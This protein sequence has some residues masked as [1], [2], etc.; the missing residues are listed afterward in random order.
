MNEQQLQALLNDVKNLRAVP[1]TEPEPVSLKANAKISSSDLRCDAPCA[2]RDVGDVRRGD[3][4]AQRTGEPPI[5]PCGAGWRLGQARRR[6]N[7]PPP[8]AKRGALAREIRQTFFGVVKR[9]LNLNDEQAVKLEQ[10]DTRFQRERNLV[11][12][13]ERQARQSLKV[14]L[15]DTTGTPDNA[16]I[17]QYM[18][19]LVQA[20]HKRA[21]LLEAEQKELAGFLTPV[22]RAQYFALRENL[23]RR[24][25]QMNQDAGEGR[26]GGPP[27]G[28]PPP[29]R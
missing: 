22:Q 9:R 19:R 11:G 18:T 5:R 26:R 7:E 16:K 25:A 14:A 17:D 6:G 8:N 1:V 28:G 2:V 20:Q 23:N 3:R 21:D 29:E 10:A 27:P 13:D 12:A 24:I 15:E 4:A